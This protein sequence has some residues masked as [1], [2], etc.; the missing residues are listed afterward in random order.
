MDSI[1]VIVRIR[2]ALEE[3]RH[4]EKHGSGYKKMEEWFADQ[5]MEQRGSAADRNRALMSI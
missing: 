5:A 4:S 1:W 3:R 2:Q